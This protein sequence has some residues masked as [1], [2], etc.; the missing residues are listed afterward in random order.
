MIGR[1]FKLH[2]QEKHA[3][4]I[5]NYLPNCR[6]FTPA[7][8][9]STAELRKLILGLAGELLRAERNS[10]DLFEQKDI[11]TT[12]DL[13][14]EWESALGIPDDVFLGD[15]DLEERRS[16]VLIKFT[17]SV[18]TGEDFERLGALLGYDDIEVTPVT[19]DQYPPYDVPF[20]PQETPP[21]YFIVWV[22]GT[23]ILE[24]V[25]P[26][27]VPFDVIVGSSFI[28]LLFDKLKPA[29]VKFIYSDK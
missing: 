26:Y 23:N 21:N 11:T 4:S 27:D 7:K 6:I 14:D 22:T 25:P 20:I 28:P 12:T 8:F 5:A 24:S 15:G 1:L 2:S 19:A 3:D 10:S 13:I 16:H 29:N 17:M 9:T 18:Q